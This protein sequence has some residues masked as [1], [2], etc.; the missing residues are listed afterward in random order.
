MTTK[1]IL[2]SAISTALL[3]AAMPTQAQSFT[4]FAQEGDVI[5]ELRVRYEGVQEEGNAKDDAIAM[6][7]RTRLGY[8]TADMAGFKVLAEYDHVTALQDE[9]NS[10][11]E[12]G[13][14]DKTK[15]VVAD[16][17][18]GDINRAQVSYTSKEFGAVLGRQRIILD[19]ARFVGN[20]GWRQN[21]Q[22]Y[23]AARIDLTAIKNLNATYVYMNQVND[24]L[25]NDLA[26]KNHLLNVGYK[27]P[28]GKVTTYAYMLEA[29]E[30]ND[31][32]TNDTYGLSFKGAAPVANVELLYAAEYAVQTQNS[33]IS[34]ADDNDAAYT[35]LEGGVKVSGISLLAGLEILGGDGDYAFETPL[36]TKHAFNGWADKFLSTNASTTNPEDGE[37]N[38]L[39][40]IYAKVAGNV[41]GVKLLAVYHDYSSDKDNIDLGSEVNLLAA[42]KFDENFSAGIKLAQYSAGDVG[43]DADKLWL[44]GEVKF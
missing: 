23:D 6:T 8:E 16:P 13:S 15:S 10:L 39:Q 31:E 35:F 5:A 17:A 33:G 7:A 43:T 36:A 9:Y 41:A 38:G 26:V 42:K 19:N 25:Y 14:D 4:E 32:S 22:T 34:G 37:I 27:T 12:L 40:D 44:W 24:I 2:A 28:V 1:I 29:D 11:T 30:K 21:E 18:T 20:V 3:A